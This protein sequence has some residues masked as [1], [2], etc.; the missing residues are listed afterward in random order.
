[1]APHLVLQTGYASLIPGFS[2][3][4]FGL[5]N[6]ANS[7]GIIAAIALF[8]ELSKFVCPKPNP[9]LLMVSISNLVL[10]QSKTA[11]IIAILGFVFLRSDE[12]WRGRPQNSKQGSS[13][14]ILSAVFFITSIAALL[15]YMKMDSLRDFLQSDRTGLI[16]FTGR[17]R[18]W[19]ITWN[20]FLSNPLFGYGPE[21]WNTAYRSQHGMM[22][23]GHAHNQYVQV[24]GQAGLL[25]ALSLAFYIILLIRKSYQGWNETHGL[26]LLIVAALL[27][28]GFAESPMRMMGIMDSDGFIHLLSFL[29]VAAVTVQAR[30]GINL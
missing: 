21:I 19:E 23:A 11:W 27:I 2:Y 10:A 15:V 24:L 29:T 30:K 20:E 6:H 22:S 4:L 8:L 18:I 3:R 25:G 9:F 12:M 1:M 14:A 16:T 26:S 17:T 28:H 7:L 13:L 5:T